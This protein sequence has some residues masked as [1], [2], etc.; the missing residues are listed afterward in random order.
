MSAWDQYF[1]R[2]Q[3][4][5][6]IA[7]GLRN[8]LHD[9]AGT[10][11]VSKDSET[12]FDVL[13]IDDNGNKFHASEVRVEDDLNRV[14]EATPTAGIRIMLFDKYQVRAEFLR[15]LLSFGDEPHLSEAGSANSIFLPQGN[16][17]YTLL[18]KLNFVERNER[19][20]PDKWSFR[21]VGVYHQRTPGFDLF[22]LL[23]CQPASELAETVQDIIE[24]E[25]GGSDELDDEKSPP[26]GAFRQHLCSQPATLHQYILSCYLDNWRAYLRH[27]G[28]G[29]SR[30]VREAKNVGNVPDKTD[31]SACLTV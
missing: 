9:L 16:D 15:V 10:A 26:M 14:L 11:F 30:I 6:P 31:T 7:A 27:L 22:I 17:A 29:F 20:G 21:H 23:H 5:F 24:E 2:Q 1:A 19:P 8:Q 18:Y 12:Q 4:G 28:S 13:D 25:D 3:G